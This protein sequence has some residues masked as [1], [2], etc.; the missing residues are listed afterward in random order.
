MPDAVMA[1]IVAAVVVF[2]VVAVTGAVK[3][4][5]RESRKLDRIWRT[6]VPARARIV[7]I[8]DT[9]ERSGGRPNQVPKLAFT[10]EV[11]HPDG[12]KSEATVAFYVRPEI[13]ERLTEGVEIDVRV[14]ELDPT[15]VAV[16][17]ELRLLGGAK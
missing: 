2:A 3:R 17:P 14:D 11:A 4:D 15:S 13:R 5:L 12:S 10:L 7:A 6:G 16:D 8:T 1:L 9:R